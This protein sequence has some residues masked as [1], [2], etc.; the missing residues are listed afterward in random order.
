MICVCPINDEF[1]SMGM[2]ILFTIFCICLLFRTDGQSHKQVSF[3]IL[4]TASAH[5]FQKLGNLVTTIH[6]PGFEIGYGFNW[7]TK[8]KHDWYQEI[9]AGYFYHRFVQHGI[10]IYTNV[11]Y[12]YKF[13]KNWSAQSA[14]GAGYF[15]SI[16]A[17]DQ[18]ELQDDGNYK[19]KKSLGRIQAMAVFNLGVGYTFPGKVP[20]KIFTTYQQQIQTPFVK[21]YVPILPYNTLLIGVSIPRKSK[22]TT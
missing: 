22:K 20:M 1:K 2:K 6:H 11:G 4:N 14:I 5:P 8:N 21:S 13:S 3:A 16:P 17:T 15:H 7:K 10:P 12:R 18:F 19:K 9:K